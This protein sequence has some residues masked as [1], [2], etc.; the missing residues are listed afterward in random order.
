M[1]YALLGL[2]VRQLSVGPRAVSHIKRIVRGM[3]LA[4][5]RE[6]AERA[7]RV[8]TAAEAEVVL[9]EALRRAL[10]DAPYLLEGLTEPV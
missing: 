7:L 10:H 4:D 1:A 9:L 6:A 5:A 8:A 3:S 2:G